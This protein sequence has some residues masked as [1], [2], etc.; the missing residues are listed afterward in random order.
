MKE[1]TKAVENWLLKGDGAK[2]KGLNPEQVAAVTSNNNTV[3]AAGA[4]AGKTF[5]LARRYAYLVCVKKLKVSEILKNIK[6][7]KVK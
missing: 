7:D 6:E 3:T 5:V 2:H 1:I 4:G